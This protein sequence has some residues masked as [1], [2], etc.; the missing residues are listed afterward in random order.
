MSQE[1]RFHHPLA[2]WLGCVA[3]AAGV[4]LHLPMYLMA[5]P[6]HYQLAGMPM[7]T[8]MLVGMVLIP[9]GVLLAGYGLMPRLAQMRRS[10]RSTL[11]RW[12]PKTP[13]YAWSSSMTT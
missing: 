11:H 13:R 12:L 6:M 7:D 8:G 1:L 4:L 3:V 9:G 10:R 2:F 5:A